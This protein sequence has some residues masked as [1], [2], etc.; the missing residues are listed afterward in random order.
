MTVFFVIVAVALLVNLGRASRRA[1]KAFKVS[2]DSWANPR[3]WDRGRREGGTMY[4][5]EPGSDEQAQAQLRLRFAL[6]AWVAAIFMLAATSR[7]NDWMALTFGNAE[8]VG[9]ALL[10]FTTV[11]LILLLQERVVEK[12][13]S[14]KLLAL[15]LLSLAALLLTAMSR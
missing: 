2:N 14:R 13:S 1:R 3:T 7:L 8:V 15:T 10:G 9:W 11:G 4:L 6:A 12:S 5:A